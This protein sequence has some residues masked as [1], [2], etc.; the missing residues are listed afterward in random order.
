VTRILVFSDVHANLTA[1]EAV[2][3]DA[4]PVEE[5]WCL[6]DVV[7]YGPDP[8]ECISR[9]NS[10]PHMA[11]LMG[12]HDM[13][14]IGNLKLDMFNGDAK[15][16]L[17]WQRENLTR[18]NMQFLKQLPV[19]M[20]VHGD[21]SLV[22]GS[23]RDP[24][25][26]YL[27]N[28]R[29][30]YENLVFYQTNWCCVGHSHFQLVFQYQQTTR[31]V[32]VEIPLPGKDYPLDDRAFLNPGSVGQPRDRDIRAAYA[33]LDTEKKTWQPGRVAYDIPQ[34]QDRIIK[35]GLPARHAERLGGGW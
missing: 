8:N 13:A 12:N 27:L 19:K 23:P 5:Y 30:A 31:E 18:E 20:Q 2:L 35:A 1:L 34:V 11:C 16:S 26:E 15:R 14:A 24:V 9:L 32:H 7:G 28:I 21:F 10:L 4:G 33:I 6:G 29:I 25:W 3:E 22:H 17:V